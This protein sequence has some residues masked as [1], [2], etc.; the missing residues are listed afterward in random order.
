MR[1]MGETF[2]SP[3]FK[4]KPPLCVSMKG[5]E[6]MND[7]PSEVNVLF[8][9]IVTADDKLQNLADDVAGY[10]KEK[11]KKFNGDRILF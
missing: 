10:F 2:H 11:S 6:C 7:D 3:Y 1:Q 4:N 8:G 5:V 9:K